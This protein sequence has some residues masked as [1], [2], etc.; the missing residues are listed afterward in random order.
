MNEIDP[1]QPLYPL[2]VTKCYPVPPV[3]HAFWTEEDW[4]KTAFYVTEPSE[5]T[6]SFM[7][8]WVAV[9]RNKKGEILY[10]KENPD[11]Q[12]HRQS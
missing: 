12:V 8:R 11:E 3:C 1:A 7:G 2:R 5:M 9:G 10:A 4:E 6:G